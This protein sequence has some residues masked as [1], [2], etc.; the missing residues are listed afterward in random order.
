MVEDNL[1]I[2]MFKPCVKK[3]SIKC[4]LRHSGHTA[5]CKFVLSLQKRRLNVCSRKRGGK[6]ISCRMQAFK[7]CSSSKQSVA[8]ISTLLLTFVSL[9]ASER[10]LA[11]SLVT[12][13]IIQTCCSH[14]FGHKIR[15]FMQKYDFFSLAQGHDR[16]HSDTTPLARAATKQNWR[17]TQIT[18]TCLEMLFCSVLGSR[19]TRSR[20]KLY[21]GLGLRLRVISKIQ[22]HLTHR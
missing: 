13:M 19:N 21:N 4:S 1:C 7:P 18:A 3:P 9:L 15:Y 14:L 8:R 20:I 16:H 6:K 2:S 22:R 11:T 10:S 17:T 12:L 5:A